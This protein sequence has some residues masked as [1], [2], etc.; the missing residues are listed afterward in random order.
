MTKNRFRQ[1]LLDRMTELD[2][3]LNAIE[4]NPEGV[5]EK[6]AR[7][8][9]D[10]ADRM[11]RLGHA[12][13]FEASEPLNGYAD[14]RAAKAYLSRCLAALHPT[15]DTDAKPSD[16]PLTV[17]EASVR[18]SIPERT[19]YALCKD[20]QLAHHRVGTGGGRIM[21]KPADLDRHLHQTRVEP[22][23][24][25]SVEDLIFGSPGSA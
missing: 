6:S 7:I 18:Y 11:A 12:A 13:L 1:W 24:A 4:L 17:A 9:Q 3:T 19:I 21:I 10:V 20:G 2:G 5:A 22:R 23:S 25:D 16:A 14:P 8:V 15:G